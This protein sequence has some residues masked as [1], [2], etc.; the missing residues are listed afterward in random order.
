M[1]ILRCIRYE[2]GWLSEGFLRHTYSSLSLSPSPVRILPKTVS[3]LSV[4]Y[5]ALT[6][7]SLSWPPPCVSQIPTWVNKICVAVHSHIPVEKATSRPIFLSFLTFYPTCRVI[8]TIT[9]LAHY[10]NEIT[11]LFPLQTWKTSCGR[12]LKLLRITRREAPIECSKESTR[13]V[14]T[15]AHL[16][17]SSRAAT[18][19]WMSRWLYGDGRICRRVSAPAN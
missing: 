16:D 15:R 7:L 9:S 14:W 10:R 6:A 4:F 5:P 18:S 13:N 3:P 19:C 17:P 12:R 8:R 1:P 2:S 11:V